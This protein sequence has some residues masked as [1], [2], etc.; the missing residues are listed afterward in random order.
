M[1]GFSFLF[2]PPPPPFFFKKTVSYHRLGCFFE[3]LG[4]VLLTRKKKGKPAWLG[5]HLSDFFSLLHLRASDKMT[6]WVM[7]EITHVID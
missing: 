2:L 1:G 5:L 6:A 4:G 3:G 7:H